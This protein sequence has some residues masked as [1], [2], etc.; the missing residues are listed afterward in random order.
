M[1]WPSIHLPG[2]M[3]C[4]HREKVTFAYPIDVTYSCVWLSSW[5]VGVMSQGAKRLRSEQ[6][7]LGTLVAVMKGR[8]SRGW[9]CQ[10]EQPSE[11]TSCTGRHISYHRA[12]GLPARLPGTVGLPADDSTGGQSLHSFKPFWPW[13]RGSALTRGSHF[14]LIS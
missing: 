6:M 12:R 3:S 8:S 1:K 14:H 4:G 2:Q 5:P 7:A 9:A 11:H 10:A 13:G